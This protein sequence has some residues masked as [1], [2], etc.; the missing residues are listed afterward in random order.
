MSDNCEIF[1]R[2]QI[3]RILIIQV[4]NTWKLFM[5]YSTDIK[6]KLLA[7]LIEYMCAVG[8]DLKESWILHLR[9]VPRKVKFMVVLDYSSRIWLFYLATLW[10][11]LQLSLETYRAKYG[12][13]IS[14]SRG[15]SLS[16]WNNNMNAIYTGL[17]RGFTHVHESYQTDSFNFVQNVLYKFGYSIEKNLGGF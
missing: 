14:S 4:S 10:Y 6:L 13:M 11:Y 9:K 16:E 1:L 15:I 17:L 7:L 2:V 5:S 12:R 3:F 8:A